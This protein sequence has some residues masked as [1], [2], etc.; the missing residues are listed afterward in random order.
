MIQLDKALRAWGTPGFEAILKQELAQQA[1]QLPLQQGLSAGNYVVADAPVTV[2]IISIVELG[3][4]IR[5]KA[6]IFYQSVITGCG[7]ADDPTPISENNEYCEVRLDIDK[8]SAA[9]AVALVTE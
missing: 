4:V 1:G 3:N 7:C 9:T 6:G 8:A 5:V 2:A